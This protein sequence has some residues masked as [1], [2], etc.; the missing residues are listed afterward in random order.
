MAVDDTRQTHPA[1]REFAHQMRVT[2]EAQAETA[3]GLRNGGAEQAKFLHLRH[4]PVRV[5]VLMLEL[6]GYRNYLAVDK[7]ANSLDNLA[8]QRFIHLLHSPLTWLSP[9]TYL[10]CANPTIGKAA[11]RS[12]DSN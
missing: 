5:L 9:D 2:E 10:I 7:S 6:T 8:V 12:C 3:I 1:A 4:Q 11:P